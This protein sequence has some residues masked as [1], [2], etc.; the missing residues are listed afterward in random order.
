MEFWRNTAALLMVFHPNTT[1]TGDHSTQR[2][3][4]NEG[5]SDYV[6]ENKWRATKCHARNTAFYTKTHP[7]HG[8]RQRSN[9]PFGRLC[10]NCATT[11]GEMTPATRVAPHGSQSRP[12]SG[13]TVMSADFMLVGIN[14]RSR[15]SFSP[16]DGP[17]KWLALTL[18]ARPTNRRRTRP[19]GSMPSLPRAGMGAGQLPFR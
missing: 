5:R 6:Y 13:G 10:T 15:K 17:G 8:N 14:E 2:D 7:S 4:K 19:C 12:K 9:G 16:T 1:H 18:V 3:V 11:R